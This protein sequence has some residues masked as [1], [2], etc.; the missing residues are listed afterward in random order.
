[1]N[2]W[3]LLPWYLMNGLNS[4]DKADRE[5]PIAPTDNLIRFWGSKVKVTA[6]RRSNLVNTVSHEL[7]CTWAMS[8]KL[9]GINTSRYLSPNYILEV[10]NQRSRSDLGSSMWWRKHSRRR[11]GVEVNL[12]VFVIDGIVNVPVPHGN[13][14]ITMWWLS[15]V[16]GW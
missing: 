13:H 7:R 8:M 2:K 12:I 15:G 10:K 1:M 16:I 3:T 4:F 14:V 5:Y 6:D 9:I 11:W